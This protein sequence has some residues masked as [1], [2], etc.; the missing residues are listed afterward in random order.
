MFC[1]R[2]SGDTTI[3][4]ELHR[5]NGR[6]VLRHEVFRSEQNVV[7]RH[8]Y[9]AP[10]LLCGHQV[11]VQLFAAGEA[12]HLRLAVLL[13]RVGGAHTD[14][15]GVHGQFAGGVGNDFQVA[16]LDARE[17]PGVE[18]LQTLRVYLGNGVLGDGQLQDAPSLPLQQVA[19]A[20]AGPVQRG[21]WG[22]LYQF[23]FG[24]LDDG[25]LLLGVIPS[26]LSVP[27]PVSVS[28]RVVIISL[29]TTTQQW[30]SRKLHTAT[31]YLD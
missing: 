3:V 1:G 4:T 24:P 30:N 22:L 7:P 16:G 2:W 6:S 13:D 21:L 8:F 17:A 11:R 31:H 23:H 15:A 29:E 26:H 9:H 10:V 5:I 12:L 19:P 25:E 20:I 28:V 27:V 18:Q 14:S